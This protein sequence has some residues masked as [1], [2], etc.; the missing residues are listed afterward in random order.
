MLIL[1]QDKQLLC[2]LESSVISIAYAKQRDTYKVCGNGY[3]LGEYANEERAKEIIATIFRIYGGASKY[4]MPEEED[5]D[6]SMQ[7]L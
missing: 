5:E 2:N 6:E 4:E 7:N 1:S 3:V